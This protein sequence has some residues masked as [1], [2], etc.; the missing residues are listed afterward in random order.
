MQNCKT[1][2]CTTML[3]CP[4]FYCIPWGYV[5]DGKWDCPKGTDELTGHLCEIV[6]Q[7]CVHLFKCKNTQRCIHFTDICDT[8]IDC[9]LG[10][11]ESMCSLKKA[12][13][14]QK[15]TCLAFAVMCSGYR[16]QFIKKQFVHFKIISM[17]HSY[18][19]KAFLASDL[20]SLSITTSVFDNDFTLCMILHRSSR[21][22][23]LSAPKNCISALAGNC[24]TNTTSLVAIYL[25]SN[26]L[27]TFQPGTFRNLTHLQWLN[28]SNNPF[29]E[30]SSNLFADLH[31]LKTL[32]LY[33]LTNFRTN[34]G[35][36]STPNLKFLQVNK[37]PMCCLALQREVC[38][39]SCPWYFTC[40]NL[41]SRSEHKI[42][43]TCMSS[44]IVASNVLSILLQTIS[45]KSRIDKKKAS[46]IQ[47]LFVNVSDV[48]NVLPIILL[49]HF[50]TKHNAKFSSQGKQWRSNVWCWVMCGLFMFSTFLSF[51]NIST[52]AYSRRMIVECPIAT[53]YTHVSHVSKVVLFI[54]LSS[55]AAAF[56]FTVLIWALEGSDFESTEL[57]TL[58]NPFVDPSQKVVTVRLMCGLNIVGAFSAVLFILFNYSNLFSSL[59]KS[60]K[61]MTDFSNQYKSNLPIIFQITSSSMVCICSWIPSG[62]IF[63]VCMFLEKYPIDMIIWTV[64]LVVPINSVANPLLFSIGITRKL[65]ARL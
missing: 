61:S 42:L 54:F 4:N 35:L 24:F 5:C 65:K 36:K 56:F 59:R 44:L 32:S 62:I 2:Q 39:A 6:E 20:F 58:C 18:I 10:D 12:I 16:H 53:K 57:M 45:F 52:V 30:L 63:V 50:D 48:V 29:Q 17:R 38:S 31:N 47:I 3:K 41:L 9:P 15:C 33:N 37:C 49:L 1:F 21:I 55:F 7:R 60:K 23:S 14:P 19:T 22:R 51:G 34:Q 64:F 46:G 26:N 27:K 28:I 40:F 25:A 13:C 43:L 8:K 11:D